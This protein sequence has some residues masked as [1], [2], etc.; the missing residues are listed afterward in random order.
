MRVHVTFPSRAEF[1]VPALDNLILVENRAEGVLI[2]AS[3]DNFSR[4]R[5]VLFVHHLAAEG[6]IAPCHEH[7][8]D[9]ENDGL[10]GV[11]W[12]VDQTWLRISPE[13]R[14][15][16]KRFMRRLLLW[17]GVLWLALMTFAF[18]NAR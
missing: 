9:L 4:R 15:H 3:R 5:K 2:R 7:P 12:V 18:L 10:L 16:S 6:F 17:S 14:R 11:R 8:F 1:Y 13:L